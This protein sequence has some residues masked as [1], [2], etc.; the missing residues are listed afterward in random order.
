MHN[1]LKESEAEKEQARNTFSNESMKLQEE[2]R[3]YIKENEKL[4]EIESTLIATCR[5]LKEYYNEKDAVSSKNSEMEI[6]PDKIDCVY[7]DK[8]FSSKEDVKVHLIEQHMVGDFKCTSCD[9]I[10]RSKN[11]FDSHVLSHRAQQYNCE[12]CNFVTTNINT[13]NKHKSSQSSL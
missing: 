2:M 10:S 12:M 4:K 8:T 7:C 5:S 13:M 3:T 6:R 11:T 9:F 1:L